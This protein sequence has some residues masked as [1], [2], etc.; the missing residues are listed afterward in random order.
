MSPEQE[1]VNRAFADLEKQLNQQ[2][3]NQ[4]QNQKSPAS[5][6]VG[7]YSFKRKMDDQEEAEF[8]RKQ[9][10]WINRALGMASD[11]NAD[12][13]SGKEAEQTDEFIRQ[14][15]EWIKFVYSG[16]SNGTDPSGGGTTSAA[17]DKDGKYGKATDNGVSSTTTTTPPYEIRRTADTFNVA[18]DVP[19]VE[20]ADIDIT[21]EEQKNGMVFL[22]IKGERKVL[23]TQDGGDAG[24]AMLKFEKIVNLDGDDDYDIDSISA[25]LNN[26]V[27]VVSVPKT[28]KEKR[29]GKKI[30][31]L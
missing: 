3:Q 19:G 22:V 15:R 31:V 17:I 4:Q 18:L 13:A 25:K 16:T 28:S 23:P 12:F 14:S 24:S 27:L 1:I 8:I 11:W 10:A 29:V 26:G 7:G 2:Q 9:Q 6:N 5:S 30:P 20:K 21:T